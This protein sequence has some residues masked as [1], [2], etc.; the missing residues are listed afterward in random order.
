MDAYV[1][2]AI[3]EFCNTLKTR[4]KE[5]IKEIR[6]FGSVA[7]G[8]ASHDSDIDILVILKRE[9]SQAEDFI[10]DTTVNVNL[11]YDVVV[12]ATTMTE[13]DYT[14]APFMET[15]FYKNTQKEG[16]PL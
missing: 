8:N 10:L 5:N 11:K 15:L 12:S 6:L 13:K 16:V 3:N 2:E 7:R 14:Y 1:W 4:L 9:D